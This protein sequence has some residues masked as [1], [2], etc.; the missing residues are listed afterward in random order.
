MFLNYASSYGELLTP[1]PTP[2]LMDHPLST[3][4]DCF[5]N[6]FVATLHTG[7]HSSICNLTMHHAMVTGTPIIMGECIALILNYMYNK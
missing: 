7:G 3:V 4:H 5:F 2:R 1:C 6:I